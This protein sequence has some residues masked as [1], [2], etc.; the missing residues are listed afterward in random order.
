MARGG[1][2]SRAAT[3]K[4]PQIALVALVALAALAPASA[5]ALCYTNF[6]RNSPQWAQGAAWSCCSDEPVSRIEF[7]TKVPNQF[8]DPVD[9][10]VT[11]YGSQ[12]GYSPTRCDVS[13]ATSTS[14]ACSGSACV[15][16]EPDAC[17]KTYQL[18]NAPKRLCL[19]GT[20][21]TTGNNA[22]CNSN[23]YV[24]FDGGE[25]TEGTDDDE[26][27][28]ETVTFQT[29]IPVVFILLTVLFHARR[30]MLLRRRS[31][32]HVP[33]FTNT[34]RERPNVPAPTPAPAP[35]VI[36]D[37]QSSQVLIP[38]QNGRKDTIIMF[39][40]GAQPAPMAPQPREGP[41]NSSQTNYVT[42]QEAYYPSV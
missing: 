26:D 34:L 10:I 37:V 16:G 15:N 18:P 35:Q 39:A 36:S 27:F 22:M 31:G 25:G 42:S 40:P 21:Q 9:W 11:E 13:L 38:G 30:I 29:L 24:R 12:S 4:T 8:Y 2:R 23:V 3:V 19:R 41:T 6:E 17:Y 33:F 28:V 1:R 20:C 5:V 7:K 14:Y 32:V